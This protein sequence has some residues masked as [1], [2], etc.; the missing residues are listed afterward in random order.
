MWPPRGRVLVIFAR[1]APPVRTGSRQRAVIRLYPAASGPA[2]ATALNRVRLPDLRQP[3]LLGRLGPVSRAAGLAAG[4]ASP[5]PARLRGL[6]RPGRAMALRRAKVYEVVTRTQADKNTYGLKP[7]WGN[8]RSG[9]Y[10]A[11]K[12]ASRQPGCR[13]MRPV[14]KGCMSRYCM[15]CC[16]S[17]PGRTQR[18]RQFGDG[19]DQWAR[20]AMAW[21]CAV[22]GMAWKRDQRPWLQQP[23][24]PGG[25]SGGPRPPGGPQ[26]EPRPTAR[27]PGT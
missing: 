5:G 22:G 6:P 25:E 24:G 21:T 11:A 26:C 17:V 15:C 13:A 4:T 16:G 7:R 12:S 18:D 27:L 10:V 1:A 20:S 8:F 19:G 3:G 23:P 2:T 9:T 14:G